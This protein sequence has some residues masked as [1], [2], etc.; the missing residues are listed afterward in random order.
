MKR[1]SDVVI[2]GMSEECLDI[3]KSKLLGDNYHWKSFNVEP[4]SLSLQRNA[5]VSRLLSL[6]DRKDQHLDC[7]GFDDQ[8]KI[9]CVLEEP[10]LTSWP[11]WSNTSAHRNGLYMINASLR[12]FTVDGKRIHQRTRATSGD[13]A[14]DH[15]I[16]SNFTSCCFFGPKTSKGHHVGLIDV[17]KHKRVRIQ[18]EKKCLTDESF[19]NFLHFAHQNW[20]AGQEVG[21]SC[22]TPMKISEFLVDYITSSCCSGGGTLLLSNT[23]SG[24]VP[25]L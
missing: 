24:I 16:R 19:V 2:L 6:I 25:K 18:M 8:F 21:L 5:V 7:H 1:I 9:H 11:A 4:A 15:L 14:P 17:Q 3:L 13:T 22:E 12:A 20:L 10:D 23:V